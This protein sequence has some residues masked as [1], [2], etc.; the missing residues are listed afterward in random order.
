M[1]LRGE[2]SSHSEN[3]VR[4]GDGR[5]RHIWWMRER[6]REGVQALHLLGSLLGRSLAWK[7]IPPPSAA[8]SLDRSQS[9]LA[10]GAPNAQM[11]MEES[12]VWQRAF[13]PPPSLA[14]MAEQEGEKGRFPNSP[15]RLIN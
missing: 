9:H 4:W 5:G 14:D 11:R 13:P 12:P 2:G 3:E 15:Y 1:Q 6:E 10:A 7:P 8:P